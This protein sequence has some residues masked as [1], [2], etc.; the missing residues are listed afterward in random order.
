MLASLILA[1]AV[2]VP[3][4]PLAGLHGLVGSW[5]CTYR[6]GATRF[7]YATT[8]AYDRDGHILRQTA[9]WTGGGDEEY[10]G[11]D[12]THRAWTAIVLDD[13]GNATVMRAPGSDPNHIA[14]QSV[15]PDA[16]MAVTFD[17]VSATAYTLHATVH[18]G[19]KTITSVDT[20][21]RR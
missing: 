5:N 4:S 10:V 1:L 21:S 20:C 19:G 16:S 3:A 14:Y 6:A 15:Y 17:R 8:Y 9:T 7:E 2:P 11:Y 13:G 18:A 12:A